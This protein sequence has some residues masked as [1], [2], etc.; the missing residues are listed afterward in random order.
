MLFRSA[1]FS[2]VIQKAGFIQSMAD[3]SLFVKKCHDPFTILLV[4]VDDMVITG[5]NSREIDKLKEHMKKHFLMKDLG[6]IRYFLGIEIDNTSEGI[7]LN[8]RKYTLELFNEAGMIDSKPLMTLLDCHE[9][10]LKEGEP[11]SNPQLY[12]KVVEKLIY[13]TITRPDI[14]FSVHILSQFMQ[15]PTIAHCKATK[16][17]LRYLKTAPRQGLFFPR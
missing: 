11:M 1:K 12:R 17:L 8:Q 7:T 2:S 10:L 13:L 16:H 5:T 3:H 4:Y 9:K 15:S 6:E 14:T